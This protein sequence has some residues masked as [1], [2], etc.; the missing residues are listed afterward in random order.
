VNATPWDVIVVGGGLAGAAAAR[1][2]GQAGQSV[3]LLEARDRVGGRAYTVERNGRAIDLGGAFVHWW[4]GQSITEVMRYGFQ[5]EF[6]PFLADRCFWPTSDGPEE[7]T[8]GELR[9]RLIHLLDLFFMDAEAVL[10][11][12]FEP[13]F[14]DRQV[15]LDHL[16]V[17]D[18]LEELEIGNDDRELLAG[19]LCSFSSGPTAA[20]G[21]LSAMRWFALH[22]WSSVQFIDREHFRIVGGVGRLVD[23]IL[24]DARCEI[25]LETPVASVADEGSSVHVTTRGGEEVRA[26]AVVLAVPLAALRGI[27]LESD[28]PRSWRTISADGVGSRGMKVVMRAKPGTESLFAV[29]REESAITWLLTESANEEGTA[30]VGFGPNGDRLDGNDIDAVQAAIDEL[31]PGIQLIEVHSHDWLA[32]E[33]THGTWGF[34]RPGQLTGLLSELQR[35][36]GRTILCG[37]ELANG[38][39]AFFSGALESGI[40]AARQALTLLE[41]G[42]RDR[43]PRTA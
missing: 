37:A 18:R 26:R 24:A 16:S 38:W 27:E 15:D 32:D 1:E 2:L 30:L 6:V 20:I 4:Q 28:I 41:S 13:L 35:A 40:R 33:F 12:P 36:H 29:G 5:L 43:T 11:R 17:R 39:V 19:V 34:L 7:V 31:A 22:R 25:R 14:G 9:E 42:S 10:P 8:K 21:L 23:A 3:L